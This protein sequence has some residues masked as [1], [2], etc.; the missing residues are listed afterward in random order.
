MARLPDKN[1]LIKAL[2]TGRRNLAMTEEE[3]RAL[4]MGVSGKD[5]CRDMSVSE[6]ATALTRMRKAGFKGKSEPQILKIRSLWYGMYE[7]GIVKSRSDKSIEAYIRR[8]TKW[9]DDVRICPNLSTVIETLKKWIERIED[10]PVRQ[11]LLEVYAAQEPGTS[12]VQ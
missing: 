3:Y 10:D 5:S 9:E 6:L 1:R 7:E 8:I 2:H 12:T 11:R 4:L